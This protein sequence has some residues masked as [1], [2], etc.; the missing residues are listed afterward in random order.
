MNPK[1]SVIIPVYNTEEYVRQAVESITQ[2]TLQEIEIIL[3]NDGS[4]DSSRYIL[5]QLAESDE[6]I[7]VFHQEN[8]GQSVARNLGIQHAT[9]DYFY[10]MDSDDLLEVDALET[11]Y[12]LCKSNQ[13]D[14]VFFD[15]QMLQIEGIAFTGLHY[16]RSKDTEENCLYTGKDILDTLLHK[17]NYSASPCLSFISNKFIQIH[18]IRFYE[19]IIHEDELFTITLYLHAQRV[20]ALHRAFFIRRIRS[21]STMT[22]RFSW[23][24]MYGYLTVAHE[25]MKLRSELDNSA[26][27]TIDLFLSKMLNAAIWKAWQLPL[28]KRIKLLFI[29]LRHY[30]RYIH[31]KTLLTMLVKDIVH[32]G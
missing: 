12:Y 14:F 6:R 15:A 1:V 8:Q 30:G 29:C 5:E 11:C 13:L 31:K 23:R 22:T 16:D 27:R 2:Q 28:G 18:C 4:M 9:G 19:G 25:V 10:F 32:S 21:D 24:N 3:I 17:N 7:R 20:M 26:K